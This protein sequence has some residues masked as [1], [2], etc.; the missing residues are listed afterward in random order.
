[1]STPFLNNIL[2][3]IK[4]CQD[5]INKWQETSHKLLDIVKLQSPETF[6][7]IVNLA[8]SRSLSEQST[9]QRKQ[10]G[11]NFKQNINQLEQNNNHNDDSNIDDSN[12]D[13]CLGNYDKVF[14]H[15]NNAYE[16]MMAQMKNEERLPNLGYSIDETDSK[17]NDLFNQ[18]EINQLEINQLENVK[19]KEADETKT[20]IIETIEEIDESETFN[21]TTDAATNTATNTAKIK[22]EEVEEVEEIEEIEEIDDVKVNVFIK[23]AKDDQDLIKRRVELAQKAAVLKPYNN[24]PPPQIDKMNPLHNLTE[25]EQTELYEQIYLTAKT[26][27]IKT[28]GDRMKSMEKNEADVLIRKECDNLL[29]IAMSRPGKPYL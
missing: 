27:V 12:I 25:D 24:T 2:A 23:K 26:N 8:N 29:Q 11:I 6:A 18:L 3:E 5:E 22:V 17:L 13:D 28:L 20:E 4:H 14:E 9:N 19:N 15:R 16:H 21:T 1:M 10:N 7:Q